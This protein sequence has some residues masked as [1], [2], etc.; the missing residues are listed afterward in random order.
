MIEYEDSL[1][2][3]LSKGFAAIERR[4][5]KF[6]RGA[7]EAEG[8]KGI[9]F[10]YVIS[11]KRH[12]KTNQDFLADFH[13]VDKSRVA[14]VIRQMELA[15]YVSREIS[16]ENRRQYMLSLTEEGER[17]YALIQKI[18]SEW[19]RMISRG[20]PAEDIATTVKTIERMIDNIDNL[21][22]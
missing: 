7:L 11:I 18:S 14:R 2:H 13:G 12:P 19:E 5:R 20:I 15:G 9:A 8:I 6:M 16:P 22:R 21:A 17:L 1:G 10:M 4:R 3:K